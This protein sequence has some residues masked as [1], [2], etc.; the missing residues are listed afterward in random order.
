LF[1]VIEPKPFFDLLKPKF[2]LKP[3]LLIIVVVILLCP[4]VGILARFI[5]HLFFN[6]NIR[7]LYDYADSSHPVLYAYIFVSLIPGIVEEFMFRGIMFNAL[8]HLTRPKITILITAVTFSF[9]HFSFISLFW[10]IPFGLFLGYLRYRYRT[11]LY[12][13]MCHIL[14]N[15]L[16]ISNELLFWLYNLTEKFWNSFCE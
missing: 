1:I 12:S 15:A 11:L 6:H 16:V 3:I 8:L 10:L 5:N 14:Y 13:I 4:F 9:I 2:K 7:Y